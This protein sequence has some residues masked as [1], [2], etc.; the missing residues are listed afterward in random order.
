M[1]TTATD[2]THFF[3]GWNGRDTLQATR[4]SASGAVLDV[5]P[6]VIGPGNPN[7]TFT[8]L[9]IVFNGTNYQLAWVR[10]GLGVWGSRVTR[11]GQLLDPGGVALL[12]N[13]NITQVAL[14]AADGLVLLAWAD[15][16]G[17]VFVASLADAT[18]GTPVEIIGNKAPTSVWSLALAATDST[19]GLAIA[20]GA[21]GEITESISFLRWAPYVALGT[22]DLESDGSSFPHGLAAGNGRF[23]LAWNQVVAG[24]NMIRGALLTSAG[25]DRAVALTLENRSRARAPAV[26]FDGTQFQVAWQDRLPLSLDQVIVSTAVSTAGVVETPNGAAVVPAPHVAGEQ[27]REEVVSLASAGGKTLAVYSRQFASD[28]ITG[29]WLPRAGEA[30]QAMALSLTRVYRGGARVVATPSGYVA[31][32]VEDSQEGQRLA[33]VRLDH[34]G[35]VRSMIDSPSPQDAGPVVWVEAAALGEHVLAVAPYDIHLSASTYY[36]PFIGNWLRVLEPQKNHFEVRPTSEPGPV[37]A[38]DRLALR[39]SGSSALVMWSHVNPGSLTVLKVS[40]AGT[41]GDAGVV[42]VPGNNTQHTV[43]LEAFDGG[44]GAVYFDE[45]Q[46]VFLRLDLEGQVIGRTELEVPRSYSGPVLL[47]ERGDE[48][49]ALVR[50]VD[51]GVSLLGVVTATG[52][53][54]YPAVLGEGFASSR[55]ARAHLG[56][57]TVVGWAQTSDAGSTLHGV[58]LTEGL[59]AVGAPFTWP[60][61]SSL[62]ELDLASSSPTGGL[63]VYVTGDSFER[64]IV[65][66]PFTEAPDGGTC[67]SWATPRSRGASCSHAPLGLLGLAFAVLVVRRRRV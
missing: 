56:D 58:R 9:S 40:S 21:R 59:E 37:W 26:S 29:A 22:F 64:N 5:P 4:L 55:L 42:M 65:W 54:S 6:L 14:G 8:V 18:L 28:I 39:A 61:D 45:G 2:G 1:P 31:L 51:G 60:I 66:R 11:D 34:D 25:L 38:F 20:A 10:P 57:D 32:W 47:V 48:Q 62:L 36:A 44:Y 67:A 7:L 50:A 19:W 63:L 41:Q 43:A 24:Q 27:R 49:V 35:A 52:E 17:R 53:S 30:G 13:E 16:M 3:V 12:A 15:N 33:G 23:L 46:V